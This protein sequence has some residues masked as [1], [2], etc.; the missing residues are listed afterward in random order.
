MRIGEFARRTGL[1][2]SAIRYYERI[3]LLPEPS[4]EP[5]GYRRYSEAD[6]ER[7]RFI[8]SAGQLGL[9]LDE[10]GDILN[11][12]EPGRVNC[13]HVVTRLEHKLDAIERWM[14]EAEA[15]RQALSRTIDASQARLAEQPMSD[16]GCPIVEL[17]L[18]EHAK[19]AASAAQEGATNDTADRDPA[20]P[21]HP[22]RWLPEHGA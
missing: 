7:L 6:E 5:S 1:K 12:S 3:G 20:H 22:L 11:A 21:R 17:G 16:C 15:M 9:T 18:Q 10:I 19:S 4:R 8:H 14:R 2:S 13:V